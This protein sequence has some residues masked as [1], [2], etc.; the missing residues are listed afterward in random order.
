M[1]KTSKT[2]LL[3]KMRKVMRNQQNMA[4]RG[5]G[6]AQLMAPLE[7]IKGEEMTKK[8]HTRASTMIILEGTVEERDFVL[9]AEA[10]ALVRVAAGDGREV[11]KGAGAEKG[12]G[13][14]GAETVVEAGAETNKVVGAGAEKD[15]EAG[16]GAG[17]GIVIGAEAEAGIVVGAGA[18]KGEEAE[19]GPEMKGSEAQNEAGKEAEEMKATDIDHVAEAESMKGAGGGGTEAAAEAG[20]GATV[21]AEAEAGHQVAAAVAIRLQKPPLLLSKMHERPG[22]THFV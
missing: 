8:K 4:G 1:K 5:R 12:E 15:A 6:A 16:T 10:E 14:A 17:A 3:V 21:P 2:Y 20:P 9:Q 11:E 13:G 7:K 19:S 18:E 22:C